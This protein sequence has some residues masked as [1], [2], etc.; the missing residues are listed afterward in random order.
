VIQAAE[1]D[2]VRPA[3]A[4]QDPH[5]LA[6][7]GFGHA[8]QQAGA[9]RIDTGQLLAERFD[10]STLRPNLVFRVLL[11]RVGDQ[12]A[13]QIIADLGRQIAAQIHGQR[14][15]LVERQPKTQ[16]KFR[17]V[18][19]QRIGPRRTVAVRVRRIGRGRQ[20]ATVDR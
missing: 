17:V 15:L 16:P 14:L 5:A 13:D 11:R 10:A 1:A 20:I 6:N 3:V 18:L 8:G 4:S 19:E 7:Q 2:I 9:R 12:F